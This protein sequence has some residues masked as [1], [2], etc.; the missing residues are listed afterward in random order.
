MKISS[1]LNTWKTAF[2]GERE[3][4]AM[5]KIQNKLIYNKHVY[6]NLSTFKHIYEGINKSTVSWPEK[7]KIY[8]KVPLY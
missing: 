7:K 3:D 1:E 8:N 5:Y 4:N 6:T 2:E